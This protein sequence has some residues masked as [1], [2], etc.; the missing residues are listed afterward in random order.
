MSMNEYINR[1]KHL[2]NLLSA[3]GDTI[4]L[5]EQVMYLIEGLNFGYS[6]LITNL[7]YKNSL[8]EVFTMMRVHEQQI[9]RMNSLT[10][11]AQ[12]MQA[13]LAKSVPTPSNNVAPIYLRVGQVPYNTQLPP[14]FLVCGRSTQGVYHESRDNQVVIA[15]S[16]AMQQG[17]GGNQSA[18]S[19]PGVKPI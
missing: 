3:A 8:E 11:D 9:Q 4:S 2:F 10:L 5:R 19:L 1:T 13:N 12:F 15:R 6:S 7:T 18:Q 17:D 14:Q 16:G